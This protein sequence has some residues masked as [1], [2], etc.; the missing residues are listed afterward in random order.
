MYHVSCIMYH[1]SCIMYHVS[2]I[3]YHVSCIMYHVSCIMYHVSC[4]MYIPTEV[5]ARIK[6]KE[7][8]RVVAET[9]RNA[10]GSTRARAG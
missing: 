10:A 1:V 4:I 2:C 7:D 8:K 6:A 5:A 9:K 3:M